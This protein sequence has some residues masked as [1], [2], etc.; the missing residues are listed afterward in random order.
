MSFYLSAPFLPSSELFSDIPAADSSMHS[1]S[2]T[3]MS[4]TEELPQLTELDRMEIIDE[5]SS[6]HRVQVARPR[7]R[8][9]LE[10]LLSTNAGDVLGCDRI[11]SA[12]PAMTNHWIDMEAAVAPFP[13]RTDAVWLG[14]DMMILDNEW[15]NEAD[16]HNDE[17]FGEDNIDSDDD[18]LEVIIRRTH[19]LHLQ[20]LWPEAGWRSQPQL[21]RLREPTWRQDEKIIQQNLTHAD[22]QQVTVRPPI[23]VD[24]T[25]E[26]MD[27]E[28]LEAEHT[29]VKVFYALLR[30]C[31]R[32]L[33]ED[34]PGR[35]HGTVQP[36]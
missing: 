9:A 15:D 36:A 35:I 20:G 10:P 14:N 21:D 7:H 22:E 16:A 25:V 17:T 3:F 8:P 27:R 12:E 19:T 34:R 6:H 4:H 29:A 1:I 32:Q 24:R 23:L 5:N 13:A 26:R 30:A 28:R 33:P 18:D 31:Q 11:P 2:R